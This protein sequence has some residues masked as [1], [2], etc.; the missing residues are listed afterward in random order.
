[1]PNEN[2]NVLIWYNFFH[3]PK[4]Y[5]ILKYFYCSGNI[6]N[7]ESA[8]MHQHRKRDVSSST[9]VNDAETLP[10]IPVSAF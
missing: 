2:D 7:A 6:F 5:N 1:M 4:P 8:I 3:F 10:Q 9:H